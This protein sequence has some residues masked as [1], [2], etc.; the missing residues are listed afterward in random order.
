MEFKVKNIEYEHRKPIKSSL[1]CFDDKVYIENNGYNVLDL[2][3]Y[4]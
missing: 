2:A 3:Y 1:F 4:K